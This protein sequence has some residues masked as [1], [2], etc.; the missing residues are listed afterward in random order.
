MGTGAKT[1]KRPNQLKAIAYLLKNVCGIS[2]III[3]IFFYFFFF[4]NF[5]ILFYFLLLC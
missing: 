1:P 3:I 5:I 2:F 4:L